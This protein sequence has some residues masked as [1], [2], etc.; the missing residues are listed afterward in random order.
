MISHSQHLRAHYR[1]A[2]KAVHDSFVYR[3]SNSNSYR[4]SYCFSAFPLSPLLLALFLLL[5]PFLLLL[6]L[7][8]LLRQ[9][10]NLL[11]K[12]SR[13][14]NTF[15]PLLSRHLP[16]A[17][18]SLSFFSPP[19]SATLLCRH[20]KRITWR[21]IECTSVCAFSLKNVRFQSLKAKGTHRQI[22]SAMAEWCPRR[23][24]AGGRGIPMA[25]GVVKRQE[26]GKRGRT[27]RWAK[28]AKRKSAINV[29]TSYVQNVRNTW[30]SRA[31]CALKNIAKNRDEVKKV[32]RE[33][34]GGKTG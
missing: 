23:Q 10:R 34:Q 2:Y 28:H 32:L 20:C 33:T 26:L 3:N 30:Q 19:P 25:M 12:H 13:A 11:Y 18:L 16:C 31:E 7:L 14:P 27:A 8:L 21:M 22:E 17:R 15:Y 9:W 5:L 6:L 29:K 24:Q 4:N 1:I